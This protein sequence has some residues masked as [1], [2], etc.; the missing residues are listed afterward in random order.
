MTAERQLIDY[1]HARAHA[2]EGVVP[3]GYAFGCAA[4]VGGDD[5]RHSLCCPLLRAA[6]LASRAI[7]RLCGVMADRLE[8]LFFFV[9]PLT[10]YAQG[11]TWTHGKTHM[12]TIGTVVWVCALEG[13][14]ARGLHRFRASARL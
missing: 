5:I 8:L 13:V 7:A 6:I 11:D 10:P 2:L 1:V 9:H 14:A 4:A 3:R 12:D